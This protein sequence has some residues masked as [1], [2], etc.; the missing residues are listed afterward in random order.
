MIRCA[1][2]SDRSGR[3]G[4]NH[5]A[6]PGGNAHHAVRATPPWLTHVVR[7]HPLVRLAKCGG[8]HSCQPRSQG[9]SEVRR[10]VHYGPPL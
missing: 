3:G 4:G 1:S 10:L 6:A 5:D 8:G 2:R 7:T 9:L